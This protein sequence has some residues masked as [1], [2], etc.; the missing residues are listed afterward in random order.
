MTR[1][2]TF[3]PEILEDFTDSD[4]ITWFICDAR[5]WDQGIFS[6]SLFFYDFSTAEQ[7]MHEN[8]NLRFIVAEV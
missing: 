6:G 7:Y 1:N 2:F 5:D 3:F 4:D 8:S